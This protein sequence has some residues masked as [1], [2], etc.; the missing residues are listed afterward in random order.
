MIIMII[1]IISSSSSIIISTARITNLEALE[2]GG[3][4]PGGQQLA[5]WK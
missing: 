1:L 2:V 4:V 3:V 5:W